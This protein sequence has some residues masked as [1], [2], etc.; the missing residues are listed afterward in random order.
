MK[1]LIALLLAALMVF[2]LCAC[3]AAEEPAE[4]PAEAPVEEAAEAPAEEAAEEPA[5]A[6]VEDASGEPASGEPA[7]EEAYVYTGEAL[8]ILFSATYSEAE[9][10]GMIIKYF[11][12]YLEELT[13]G[14]IT[15]NVTYGGTLFGDAD[16]LDGVAT[17]AV[18]M[19]CLGH[20]PHSAKLPLLCSVPDFAPD[21]IQN[22]LDYFNTL[23]FDDPTTSAILQAE[24]TANGIKY[25]NVTAGGANTFLASFE[26]TDLSSLIAGSRA[27][28]NMEPAKFE[29]LGFTVEQVLPWDYYSAF[30]TGLID[31]S[32]M[33]SSALVSMG[34]PEVA[35]YWMYDNTYTAG[36]FLTANLAWWD[37]LS[38]E[39]QT[40]I[41]KAADAME[42]YS[43]ELYTETLATEAADLE[44]A[45]V[46]LVEMSDAD[47]ATWWTAIMES[48][49][50]DALLKAA[51]NG[52]VD[53]AKAILQAAADFTGYELV[54]E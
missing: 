5:E 18:N 50:D 10:G 31:A 45:G 37:G 32:Q 4:E 12:D 30:S 46:T 11:A 21:T 3:G 34:L 14:A 1:K 15:V 36:N 6:P 39:Q 48:K 43:V 2:A 41:Q 52:N 9:T 54:L 49:A 19:I 8:N 33:A 47:F 38:A 17:G 23:I 53:D 20:N 16:Q 40:A 42:A 22:A 27:F 51:D 29:A 25:L 7:A 24:A 26:F 28:G 35:Q 44:A 13:G